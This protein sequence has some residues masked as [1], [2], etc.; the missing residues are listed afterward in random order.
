MFFG[1]KHVQVLKIQSSAFNV[2]VL[3]ARL[4]CFPY[5]SLHI[6]HKYFV[7]FST[8]L[9]SFTDD[10]SIFVCLP[11]PQLPVSHSAMPLHFYS[12]SV[13]FKFCD[14]CILKIIDVYFIIFIYININLNLCGWNFVLATFYVCL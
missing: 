10:F 11:L 1:A 2:I 3:T 13:P 6:E 4:L 9:Y 12:F 7:H 8:D 14:I 5:L